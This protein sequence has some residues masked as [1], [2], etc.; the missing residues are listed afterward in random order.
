MRKPFLWLISVSSALLLLSGCSGLGAINSMTSN[1]GYHVTSNL[2]Y[3]RTTGDALDVYNFASAQDAPVVV[4]FYGDRWTKGS[5]EDYKFVGQALTSQGFVVVIADTRK[6]PY[7]RFPAFMQDAAKTVRW[8]HEN[9]K[10]F[11]GDPNK[12]FVMGHDSG[13]H[14]GALLALNESYLKAVGGSR[15]WLKGMIGLA[16]PYDFMPLTAPDLRDMFGPPDRYEQSQP[17]MYTDGQNVPL[18]LMHAEDDQVVLIK[19]TR[20][21]SQAVAKAGGPVETLTYPKISCPSFNSH[22]CILTTIA[23][24]LRN[25]SDVLA[26]ITDF[27]K[28]RVSGSGAVNPIIPSSL[29]TVP[30]GE[31]EPAPSQ[32]IVEEVTPMEP[33]VELTP[34][35]VPV[36][37][38]ESAPALVSEPAPAPV[39]Q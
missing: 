29:Q 37:V 15:T 26:G 8:T 31:A 13:A 3:D 1:E 39:V 34:D 9:I 4:F 23:A 18:L 28:R 6:Y 25:Q 38:V 24:P 2:Q 27:I 22:L 10:G 17:I 14:I 12:I 33:I 16:G 21:L 5:R 36:P 20:T 35:G 19:N 32:L 7:V 30:E 11:G